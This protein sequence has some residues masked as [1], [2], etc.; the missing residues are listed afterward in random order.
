MQVTK[1]SQNT[2]SNLINSNKSIIYKNQNKNTKHHVLKQTSQPVQQTIK[3]FYKIIKQINQT[4]KI[5]HNT[6]N[7]TQI[8]QVIIQTHQFTLAAKHPKHQQCA[9]SLTQNK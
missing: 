2:K 9:Q 6:I 5:H 4:N 3:Q 1:S 7:Q 8:K